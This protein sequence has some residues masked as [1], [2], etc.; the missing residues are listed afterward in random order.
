MLNVLI[1]GSSAI[2]VTG[3]NGPA[4]GVG[5]MYY[6]IWLSF[7]LSLRLVVECLEEKFNLDEEDDVS[8]FHQES[9]MTENIFSCG[10]E[11]NVGDSDQL[12]T[13]K[14][15]EDNAIYNSITSDQVVAKAENGSKAAAKPIRPISE[16]ASRVRKE[17]PKRLRR[18]QLS[19]STGRTSREGHVA[20]HLVS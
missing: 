4:Q 7:V 20:D 14:V 6:S 19:L 16:G 12:M 15:P 2:L 10:K 9:T 11:S 1:L 18:W 5:N 17:R 13:F 8:L 3:V